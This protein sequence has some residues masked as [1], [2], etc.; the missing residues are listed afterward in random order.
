MSPKLLTGGGGNGGVLK[1]LFK[2]V[3]P[4]QGD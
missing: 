1:V 2:E 3:L 4:G